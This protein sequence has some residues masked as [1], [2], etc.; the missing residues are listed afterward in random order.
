MTLSSERLIQTTEH[1]LRELIRRVGE[2]PLAIRLLASR[3]QDDTI[4]LTTFLKDLEDELRRAEQ[5]TP[6]SLEDPYRQA[7]LYACIQYSITY[8]TER[9]LQVLHVISIFQAPFP[10]GL[11][12]SVLNDKQQTRHYLSR[13]VRLSLLVYHPS[14][15][16]DGTLDLF[17]LHLTVRWYIQ[18]HLASLSEQIQYRYGLVYLDLMQEA[19]ETAGGYDWSAATRALVRQ[20]L[21]DAEAALLVLPPLE[22]S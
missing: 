3:F 4:D 20:S 9:E 22:K 8:L 1:E 21:V 7:T 17:E 2:H 12:I 15:Y 19:N 16:T 18:Y 5:L 13:L 11:A 6:S 10:S 14:T